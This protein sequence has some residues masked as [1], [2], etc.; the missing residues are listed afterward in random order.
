M[1]YVEVSPGA[2]DVREG[3]SL[4]LESGLARVRVSACGI[5]GTDVHLARGMRL[6]R[7]VSY[8]VRPGHEVAGEV[9]EVG[10]GAHGLTPGVEVVLHVLDPCG[11]C[12]ECL[13][14]HEQQ[15]RDAR[16]L[17]LHSFGGMADE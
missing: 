13:A 15:C 4:P 6:P 10:P 17:G 14:G 1:R 9:L 16:V 2:V 7:G 12:R 8:P 11:H 3:P 5:C